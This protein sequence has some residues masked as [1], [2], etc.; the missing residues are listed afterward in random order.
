[1]QIFS[2][3]FEYLPKREI[4]CDTIMPA[5]LLKFVNINCCTSNIFSDLFYLTNT[6]LKSGHSK[7]TK[8]LILIESLTLAEV[9]FLV[10]YNFLYQ[11][12]EILSRDNQEI[13][14]SSGPNNTE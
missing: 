2:Y 12:F 10:Q 1:M 6:L 8:H 11:K 14:F 5:S 9:P 13:K 4:L 7:Q 3:Y